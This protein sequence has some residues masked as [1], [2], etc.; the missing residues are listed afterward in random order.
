MKKSSAFLISFLISLVCYILIF[1]PQTAGHPEY[2]ILGFFYGYTWLT[3][4][5]L[6]AAF[7]G[8]SIPLLKEPKLNKNLIGFV[9]GLLIIVVT[10]S[11]S[12][13]FSNDAILGVF[14]ATVVLVWV[15]GYFKLVRGCQTT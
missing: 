11:W 5:M 7:F 6:L 12:I 14:W 15:T 8:G 1:Y 4:I 10:I 2:L 13:T 9:A 3:P